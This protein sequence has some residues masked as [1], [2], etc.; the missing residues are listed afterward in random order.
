MRLVAPHCPLSSAEV[1]A[2][3]AHWAL[4]QR[5]NRRL[6]LT[7]ILDEQEAAVRHFGEAAFLARWLP[8][9][10]LRVADV[11]SG[12][13]F[14]GMPLAVLRPECQVTLIESHRRKAVFLREASRGFSNVRVV[15]ERA[16][17]V[18]GTFDWAV[19]RAVAW[20]ELRPF[21]F[22][23]A[24]ALAFLGGREVIPGECSR[25]ALPWGG[26]RFLV[27]VSR[28]TSS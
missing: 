12:A 17:S 25:V 11:G 4:V 15:A 13:G 20:V 22:D 6:N 28:E 23:L 26:D 7:R 10:R 16:E 8:P 2:F 18:S 5:W 3:E 21:I 1:E 24:P 14:P 19:S 9:G 27:A